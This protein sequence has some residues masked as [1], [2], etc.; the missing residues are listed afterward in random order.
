MTLRLG[1]VSFLNAR[2]L[3][4]SLKNDP[5]FVLSHSVPSACAADLQAGRV[6]VGLIPSIEYARSSA[7]YEIVPVMAIATSGEVLTVRLYYRKELS[8]VRRVALDT[9]SRT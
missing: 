9:S 6:D 2:P 1:V 4:Y 7:P 5:R 8:S 3:V